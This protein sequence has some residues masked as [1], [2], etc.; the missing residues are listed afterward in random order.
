MARALLALLAFVVLLLLVVW[1]GSAQYTNTA[2]QHTTNTVNQRTTVTITNN[3]PP[4][5]SAVALVIFAVAVLLFVV[6][7]YVIP[8]VRDW[9]GKDA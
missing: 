4:D 5:Y 2:V 7:R 6:A 3:L 1:L 9:R 8:A